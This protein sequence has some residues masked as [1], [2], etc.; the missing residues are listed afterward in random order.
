LLARHGWTLSPDS[1]QGDLLG[2]A[3]DHLAGLDFETSH[4][5]LDVYAAAATSIAESEVGGVPAD[6]RVVA[7]ERVVVGTLLLEPV[8][9]TIRRIAQE[10]V[11]RRTDRRRRRR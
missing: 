7:A 9:L 4:G 5:L 10:N 8:L 1:A 3:L 11:S 6:D 2:Q